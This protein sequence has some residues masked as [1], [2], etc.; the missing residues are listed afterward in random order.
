MRQNN[1]AG[2][3][4]PQLEDLAQKLEKVQSFYDCLGGIV[5][6]QLKCLELIDAALEE[7]VSDGPRT[8]NVEFLVPQGTHLQGPEARPAA[9]K[10]AA[11]GLQAMP[12]LAEIYPLGGALPLHAC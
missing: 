5:G 7:E 11:D 12:V 1:S 8:S 10:A 9:L 4:A 3:W 2:N 6:Y